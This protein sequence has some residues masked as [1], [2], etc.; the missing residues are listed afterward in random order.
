MI[1][2]T[3]TLAY[4]RYLAGTEIPP[5]LFVYFV[6]CL[7]PALIKAICLQIVDQIEH[8]AAVLATDIFGSNLK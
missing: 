7:C 3:E 2:S 8:Y 1:T 4:Y 6:Y 5:A